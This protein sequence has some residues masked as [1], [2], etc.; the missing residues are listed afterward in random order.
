MARMTRQRTEIVELLEAS[1][2][3]RSAQQLH[4]ALRAA[5]S[6]TGLATVYRTINK[7]A[8]EGAVDVLRAED[9]EALYR[10]CTLESHHHHLVCRL[11]GHTV[12]LAG[13]PIEQ[14]LDAVGREHGF[15]NVSH[16][17]ELLGTCNACYARAAADAEEAADA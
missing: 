2:D 13:N 8:A 17:L 16:T 12:E 5:G 3:F 14:W 6:S 1:A 11:C 15:V 10:L 7:L 4:E 9:G